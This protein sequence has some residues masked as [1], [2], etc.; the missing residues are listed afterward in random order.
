MKL[1][2]KKAS[3]QTP[4]EEKLHHTLS[5]IVSLEKNM[6]A[7]L[8]ALCQLIWTARNTFKC[9]YFIFPYLCSSSWT[10]S[11]SRAYAHALEH[12]YTHTHSYICAYAHAYT[13]THIDA[14]AHTHEQASRNKKHLVWSM[15]NTY[16]SFTLSIVSHLLPVFSPPLPPFLLPFAFPSVPLLFCFVSLPLH[17]LPFIFSRIREPAWA[18]TFKGIISIA[19]INSGSQTR[20]TC[21]HF[22]NTNNERHY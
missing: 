6:R 17:L 19:L 20:P 8:G 15:K 16:S 2:L 13:Q 11:Q 7:F 5:I 3:F 10:H 14:F 9:F 18:C 22:P 4:D 12:T 1:K 21:Q